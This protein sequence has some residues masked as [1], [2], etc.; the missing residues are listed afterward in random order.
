VEQASS[1]FL[2]NFLSNTNTLE[3]TNNK[4]AGGNKQAGSPRDISIFIF[5]T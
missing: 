4:Q 1:L 3:A 2:K 5:Q